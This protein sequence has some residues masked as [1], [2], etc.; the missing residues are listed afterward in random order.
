MP[1][2]VNIGSRRELFWDEYLIDTTKTT[3]TLTLHPLQA[4]EVVIDHDLP[5]EGDGCDFHCILKD[6]DLYRMYYLGWEMLDPEAKTH[7]PR[8]IVVCYAE[9]T[10]GKTWVKPQ[11]G[12]CE[13]EGSKENNIIL[14]PTEAVFDNFFVFKDSNP[15]CPKDER[16]KGIGIDGRD[17]YLWC[18]TSEDAIHFK[19]AWPM[20]NKG[21]FDTLNTVFWDPHTKQ[22]FCYIRDFHDI[23][24]NDLNAG[25]RD[26]RWMVSADFRNWTEPKLLDF[27]DGED[28][29]LYTNVIQPYYRAEHM[30]VGFPSRYVEKKEWTPNFDQFAGAAR[31]KK[32]MEVSPRYGL[33]ITDCVFMSSR[34]GKRWN[35]WDEALITPGLEHEFNWVYGDCFPAVGMIETRNDLPYAPN[36]ISMYIFEN[37]WSQMPA[38]LRRYTIRI[39]GFVS[40]KATYA[41]CVIATNPFIFEGNELSINFATSARGY[42]KIK[43]ISGDQAI[44]SIEMFGNTHDK[45]V[46]FENGD[47]AH[48]AGKPVVMEIMLSDADV[49]S[50]KFN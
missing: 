20:T 4:K 5:W 38:K 42:V 8:P 29:P 43:L 6:G 9:S 46:I 48:F 18:Y 25:I 24:N 50:F 1:K 31:R 19:K 7:I 45:K 30:F 34:D 3:A 27:G 12:I 36:E 14:D 32:R 15:D 40:Y 11:L 35:R 21:K 16:Y 13:F 10:D 41:P 23:P 22:Y 17:H 26:I 2:P 39:D 49:Y 47:V 33:A 44:D 37:H 28:Y